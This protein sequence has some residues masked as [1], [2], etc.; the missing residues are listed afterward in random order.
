MGRKIEDQMLNFVI[1]KSKYFGSVKIVGEY[2][3]TEKN[4]PVKDF[5]KE[6]KDI[7]FNSTF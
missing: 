6:K 5:F 4:K 1:E 2:L 7:I 3:P